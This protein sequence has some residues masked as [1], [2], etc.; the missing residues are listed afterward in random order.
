MNPSA[1][2]ESYTTLTDVTGHIAAVAALVACECL[3]ASIHAL[4]AR[5]SPVYPRH[6]ACLLGA[7]RD[8]PVWGIV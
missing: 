2:P 5:R 8:P 6:F 1:T 4:V 3:P 7:P